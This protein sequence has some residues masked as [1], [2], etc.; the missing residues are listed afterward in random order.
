MVIQIDSTKK[1]AIANF[2]REKTAEGA[3]IYLPSSI[4][5]IFALNELKDIFVKTNKV[6][7][8][9]N[10]PTFI[11]K[12]RT[13]EKN[14]KEFKLE[15]ANREREVSECALEI[16]LKNGLNQTTIAN[17]CYLILD[18][19]FDVRSVTENQMFNSNQIL[20]DNV[21]GDSYLIQ[22][23]NIEFSMAGLGFYDLPR[24]DFNM[25]VNDKEVINSYRESFKEFW[26]DSRVVENVK[27]E[28]LKHIS[29]IY[30]ENSPELAYYITL[31][32]LF[33][34]KLLNEDEYD[35]I[36]EATG[37]TQTKIWSMLYNF[38]QDAVVGAIHKIQKY[39]GCIIADSVG[40]GKTFEALAVI[41]YYELRNE[42][43]LVLCPKKLRGNWTGFKH[44]TKT[45]PLVDDKFRYD[46]LNHTD[47]SR[48][49][50]FSG[51][52]DLSKINWGNY[53][54]VVI[55]ESHAFRNSPARNDRVTR[56]SRLM[57]SII[58]QGV[59]TKV[60]MLSATPVNNRLTDLKNQISFITRD[61]D[62]ALA[63]KGKKNI[64]S[65]ENTLRSAQ[66]VFNKMSKLPKE[67]WD[68]N[69]LINS[70]DYAFF[71]ILDTY[72]IARSRKHIQKYYDTNAIGKFPE[73]LK[74]ISEYCDVASSGFRPISQINELL[75]DNNKLKLC[76]YNPLE[77]LLDTKKDEYEEKYKTLVKNGKS[78]FSQYD[79]EKNLVNLMRINILKRLESGV[80]SYRLTLSR[81]LNQVNK[82]LD[83][84]DG[85][86]TTITDDYGWDDYDDEEIEEIIDEEVEIGG[87]IKVK[88][89]D[90]DL[91]RFKADLSSDQL[92]LTSLLKE[93]EA[94]KPETDS[95]LEKLKHRIGLKIKH[96][97]NDGNKKII[98]FT[99]F[100]DTAKYLYEN[101]AQWAL[102]TY[103]LYSG[104]ITGSAKVET[105]L[106]GVSNSFESILTY[107]SPKSNHF[108]TD[109][110]IDLLF[111]TDCISEGQ[112]LQDCDYLINYD[113]HWNPVRIIQ[114][115]GRIDR[116]GS[117]NDQIQ[118]VNFWPN[119]SLDE[120]I[121]LEKRVRTRM[122]M[123]DTTATGEDDLLSGGS[124]ELEYRAEQLKQ[125]QNDV[126]DL[127]SIK[128]GISITDLTLSDYVMA[129]SNFKKDHPGLL[130][131]YPTGIYAVTD[132]NSKLKDDA[133][134]GVIFCLKQTK[135]TEKEKSYSSIHPYYLVYIKDNGEILVKYSNPKLV[136]D[137][138]KGLCV[139]NK[140]VLTNLVEK[141][142]KETNHASDMSKYTEL[143]KKVVNDIK[144][145]VE[146]QGVASLFGLGA[147][148]LISNTVQG[149]NDF[150]LISFLVVK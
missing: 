122:I 49:K 15:M 135:Y 80:D 112:N 32:N 141:F 107:F 50:G 19:K 37:I 108:E 131:K 149:I 100:S 52:I 23:N 67:D 54:L 111:A 92:L 144:G 101:I 27:E 41:K 56:Y 3:T 116:I 90:M 140:E 138:Y 118:L 87:K 73:R 20:I 120:Y 147:S 13:D 46:V 55:D 95:K 30:K 24:F 74:P 134:P 2:I 8:L 59:K 99:A 125:L 43:V 98:I 17:Q 105:N 44:N 127:E 1:G 31:Y 21:T 133:A 33:N 45:N 47:L 9:F 36:K 62:A 61:N 130:E 93:A 16:S 103:G 51:E 91:I 124:K 146:Q 104:I 64:Q 79:R 121:K 25:A 145:V 14:V 106:K 94:V 22:G 97:I 143:L 68:T 115:F 139:N 6:K 84:I 85:S 58:K 77:Y 66:S 82:Y 18:E 29:N 142:N 63:E 126:V 26:N 53:D 81:I 34:E 70:L 89:A 117:K 113:I 40:L 60:L 4:F 42:R 57:E 150:E 38:Q 136:L 65:I 129:L 88:L 119:Q 11:K 123:V 137:I 86:G 48:E 10:K 72:T 69:Q 110:E 71:D 128:G 39:D 35:K 114:R 12:I 5:T 109:K 102:D 132:I 148:T 28:L 75:A 96:P 83:I 7:F 78:V 76:I